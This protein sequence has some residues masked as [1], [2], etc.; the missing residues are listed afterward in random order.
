MDTHPLHQAPNPEPTRIQDTEQLIQYLDIA[1]PHQLIE[2]ADSTQAREVIHWLQACDKVGEAPVIELITL[3][4]SDDI[5]GLELK[6]KLERLGY[7]V[8]YI[9]PDRTTREIELLN[10]LRIV[11]QYPKKSTK[12]HHSGY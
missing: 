9:P 5:T 3:N 12:E 10:T 6:M 1:E 4:F 7:N 2:L 11:P 8:F